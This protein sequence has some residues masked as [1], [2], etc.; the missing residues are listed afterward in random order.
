MKRTSIILIA[1]DEP[2]GREVMAALLRSPTTKWRSPG[3][4]GSVDQ[5]KAV[6]PTDFAGRDDAVMDGLACRRLR[7]DPVLAEVPVII[8]TAL[9]D[10]TA[11][12][13]SRWA[14]TISSASHNRL[15]CGRGQGRPPQPLRRLQ[16]ERAKFEW[17]WSSRRRLR[18]PQRP[19]RGVCQPAGRLY[20]TCPMA[21]AICRGDPSL[22]DSQRPLPPNP[23]KPG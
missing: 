17:W 20:L 23:W 22:S 10:Q 7:A 8:V 3:T 21:A 2:D 15:G 16:L 4:G 5:A 19:G 14:Q 9:G 1:D 6:Q 18:D 12:R 11:S 13:A